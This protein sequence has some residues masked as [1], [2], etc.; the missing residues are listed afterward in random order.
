MLSHVSAI[1]AGFA[2][3]LVTAPTASVQAARFH[4]PSMQAPALAES[5]ACRTVRERV[6]RP[7]GSVVFRTKQSCGPGM[8]PGGP[9]CRVVRERVQRPNGSVV[10]RSVRRCG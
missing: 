3:L 1:G 9:R 10:F 4:D 8:G 2:V 5:V 6:V 7:N